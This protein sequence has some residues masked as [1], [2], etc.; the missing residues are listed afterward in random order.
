[1]AKYQEVEP[2][3]GRE[4]VRKKITSLRTNCRKE[5]VKIVSSEKSGP[6]ATDVYI[7][8]LWYFEELEFL[9]DNEVATESLSSVPVDEGRNNRTCGRQFICL[10]FIIII[11]KTALFEPQPSFE[12]S[13]RFDHFH[14]FGF[15]NSN[16]FAEQGCQPCIQ[17]PTW[18][19]RSLYLCPPE[20]G[21]PSYTPRPWV[22][23]SS[24]SMTQLQWSYSVII[25]IG[26]VVQHINK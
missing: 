3:A 8:T 7:P 12:D 16:F 2:N 24:P 25:I 1:V 4:T 17:P 19:T 23:F 11:G 18:R 14:L 20:T 15:C 5:K 6:A 26:C 10:L 13:A 22:P 21:W 9:D